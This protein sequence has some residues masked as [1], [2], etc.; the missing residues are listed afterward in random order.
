MRF[1][2]APGRPERGL[3]GEHPPDDDEREQ[4]AYERHG[5]RVSLNGGEQWIDVGIVGSAVVWLHRIPR[6]E[7]V[8]K[9]SP[10]RLFG[11]SPHRN[12]HSNLWKSENKVQLHPG[13]SV[14]R[15]ANSVR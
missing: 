4:D 12:N 9:H 5:R 13:P 14:W 11:N 8:A 6:L 15:I 10:H 2:R 3:E 7:I 1:K